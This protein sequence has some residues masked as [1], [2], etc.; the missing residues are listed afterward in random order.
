MKNEAL[1]YRGWVMSP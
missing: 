1:W